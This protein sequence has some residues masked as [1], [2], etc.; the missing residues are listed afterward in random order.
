[1]IYDLLFIKFIIIKMPE[2]ILLGGFNE[3]IK[4]KYG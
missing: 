3:L 2:I 4:A 1:M